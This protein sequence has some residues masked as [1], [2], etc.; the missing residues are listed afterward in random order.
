ML[1]LFLDVIRLFYLN[2]KN[3][4]EEVKLTKT[5]IAWESDKKYKFSNGDGC[6]IEGEC[7]RDELIASNIKLQF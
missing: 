2:D 6:K 1:R 5:N 7:T 4:R 3:D